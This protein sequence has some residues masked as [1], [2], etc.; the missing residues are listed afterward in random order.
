MCHDIYIYIDETIDII[1]NE[2][3]K[4]SETFNGMTKEQF[5]EL[6]EL[7]SKN[8][9]FLFN[10]QYRKQID[11]VAMGSPLGPH[12]A[13]A[14][15]CHFESKWLEDCPKEFKPV[16]YRRYVDDI[17]VLFEDSGHIEKYKNYMNSLHSNLSFTSEKE[18]NGTLAFLDIKISRENDSFVTSIFRKTTFSGVYMN[19]RSFLPYQF[20]TNLILTLLHRVFSISYNWSIFFKELKNLKQSILIKKHDP[21][22]NGQEMSIELLLFK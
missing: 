14:F 7:S 19:F 5:K 1:T 9:F 11:G 4:N 18:K 3:F 8:A 10:D 6:L 15:L 16:Y 21:D 17:F 2:L 22:L 13:N 12:F 20:K